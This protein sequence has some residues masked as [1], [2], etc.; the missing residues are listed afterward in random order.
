MASQ[1]ISVEAKGI[2]AL[3]KKIKREKWFVH[4]QDSSVSLRM[5][6]PVTLIQDLFAIG[7]YEITTYKNGRQVGKY[8]ELPESSLGYI[9]SAKAQEMVR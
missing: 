1:W 4:P 8:V 3:I 2:S 5:K 7:S 9:M 6:Y